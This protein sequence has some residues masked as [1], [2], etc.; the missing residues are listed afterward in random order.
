M[1]KFKN[2]D[3]IEL[4][5]IK[6]SSFASEETHCYEAKIYLNGKAIFTASNNGRGACDDYYPIGKF[7]Y[8]DIQA[9]DQRLRDELPKW[10]MKI[11][12]TIKKM[13]NTLEMFCCDMVNRHLAKR[14]FNRLLKNKV[15]VKKP[16]EKDLNFFTWKNTKKI[17]QQHIDH[18]KS[19]YKEY[20]ILN[21]M[22][23]D[24]AFEIFYNA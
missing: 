20:E 17:T 5:A 1:F 2:N 14:D 15:L 24:Q 8:S 6:H 21:E 22:P 10:D 19:K 7:T 9:I 3:I 23:Y 11:E 18:I 12:D 4:K 16:N 13:D